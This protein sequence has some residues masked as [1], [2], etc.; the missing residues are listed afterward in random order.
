VLK[1]CSRYWSILSPFVSSSIILGHSC[2]YHSLSPHLSHSATSTQVIPGKSGWGWCCGQL[3]CVSTASS[4]FHPQSTSQ[5]VACGTWG[6]EMCCLCIG[7]VILPPAIFCS[8]L[9]PSPGLHYLLSTSQAAVTAVGGLI[10]LVSAFPHPLESHEP[11]VA[12]LHSLPSSSS[13]PAGSTHNP[14]R[15][16]GKCS[17]CCHHHGASAGADV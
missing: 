16:G 2:C 17:L 6:W 13:L 14:H 4:S 10:P 9:L 8:I 12:L 3:S 5:A 1:R 15:Y 11:V 7:V